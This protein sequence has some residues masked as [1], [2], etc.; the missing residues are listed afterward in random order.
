[1][2]RHPLFPVVVVLPSVINNYAYG[3]I[4]LYVG[5]GFD[6]I[7]H[8]G[9][10]V[11]Q[12]L[13]VVAFIEGSAITQGLTGVAR[14]IAVEFLAQRVEPDSREELYGSLLGKSQTFHG[15]QRVGDIMAR[16]TN[17]VHMLALMFSPGA[18]LIVDSMLAMIVPFFMILSIKS[19]L[20]V[21]PGIFLV[22]LAIT[23]WDCN[24]RPT[25]VSIGQRE[26]FGALNSSLAGAI[27]GVEVVKSNVQE[28]YEWKKFTGN[29]RAFRDSFVKQGVV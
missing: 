5:H 17:D 24:K 13:I 23:L 12:L 8:A 16:A 27:S 29:A 15:R 11:T 4:Q 28:H 18:G 14:N 26:Q 6:V 2:M 10:A 9:W 3:N 22:L 20:G 1:M 21:V 19:V 7:T 25:P